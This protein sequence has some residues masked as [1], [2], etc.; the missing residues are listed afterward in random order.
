MSRHEICGV[1]VSSRIYDLT[2]D[3][4][5]DY[6]KEQHEKDVVKQLLSRLNETE[7]RRFPKT[8]EPCEFITD[9][10]GIVTEQNKRS[11]RAD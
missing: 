10:R 1:C 2:K 8:A 3:V 6:Q 11:H 7:L 5:A 9:G 4:A